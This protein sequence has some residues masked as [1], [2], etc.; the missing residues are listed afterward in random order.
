MALV[1]KADPTK[2]E[3]LSKIQNPLLDLTSLDSK[4]YSQ[5]IVGLCDSLL[6]QADKAIDDVDESSK[7]QADVVMRQADTE[8][9][10]IS[11]N[12]IL[13]PQ[14]AWIHLVDNSYGVFVPTIKSKPNQIAPLS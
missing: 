1:S 2:A 5:T 7:P 3:A 11:N 9:R 4:I 8:K 12:N 14:H 10:L 13:K 6:E